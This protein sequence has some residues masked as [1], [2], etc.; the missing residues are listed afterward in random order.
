M[1]LRKPYAFIIRHFKLIHLIITILLCVGTYKA[2]VIRTF[3]KDYSAAPAILNKLDASAYMDA[4]TNTAEMIER[5]DSLF[6]FSVFIVPLVTILLTIVILFI[7]YNKKKPYLLYIIVILY[8]MLL[9]AFYGITYN[10]IGDM[11]TVLVDSRLTI[12]IKD[13]LNLVVV[14]G[15]IIIVFVLTR[16]T[17]FDI[18]KFNFVKDL[19]ELN[20]SETDNEEFEVELNI[21][22]NIIRRKVRKFFRNLKYFY[23]EKKFLINL[24]IVLLLTVIG[25]VIYFVIIVHHED[26]NQNSY[27]GSKDFTMHIDNVYL[28]NKDYSG[29]VITNKYLVI[30]DLDVKSSYMNGKKMDISNYVLKIGD[31]EYKHTS[32]YRDYLFDIGVVYDDQLI[33]SRSE[34]NKKRTDY[35]TNYL[36]VYEIPESLINSD[37]ILR[38]TMEFD[39]FANKLRP[40]Y[41]RVKLNPVNLDKN[42]VTTKYDVEDGIEFK[43]SVMKDLYLKLSSYEI[44]SVIPEYYRFCIDTNKCYDSVE[45]ITPS[46]GNVE[47]TILKIDLYSDSLE[48]YGI[49]NLYTFMQKFGKIEYKING[50][51]KQSNFINKINSNH[52]AVDNYY[53]EI[54]K[55]IEDATSVSLKFYIRNK[56][57]EYALKQEEQL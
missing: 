22:S 16:A 51:N 40:K 44:N 46:I 54:P 19:E 12:L 34:Q 5:M 28:T 4:T 55:E 24:S 9:L 18:K 37:M 7:L 20:I 23:I 35:R 30:L 49:Y 31:N 39:L 42:I 36:L 1:I 17:G 14:G 26:Y 13:L 50:V 45:Y 3:L 47:K 25:F 6:S 38:Y 33:Y 8:S 21:D 48:Q 41:A 32:K 27:F 52:A 57:Y 2:T 15:I 43:D 29:N 56:V 11:E 53:I 10:I